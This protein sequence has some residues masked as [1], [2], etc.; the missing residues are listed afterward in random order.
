VT[1]TIADTE[2]SSDV[3]GETAHCRDGLWYV[4]GYPG[5]AMDRNQ[6]ITAMMLAERLAA[7]YGDDDLQVRNWRAELGLPESDRPKRG[8]SRHGYSGYRLPPGRRGSTT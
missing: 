6:A 4:T 8:S 5:R 2:I 1:L 7:G 3:A